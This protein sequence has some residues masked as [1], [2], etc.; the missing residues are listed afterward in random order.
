MYHIKTSPEVGRGLYASRTILKGETV[1]ICEILTLSPEDTIKIN[2]TDLKYYTFKLDDSRD[3][4]VLGDGE[5]FNHDDNANVS[6]RF[7]NALDR[8]RMVFKA[9][10]TIFKGEQLFIDYNADIKVDTQDYK[11]QK[12]LID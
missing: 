5:I 4:L 11:Q 1:S 6:Y 3:C 12:S 9:I 7:V 8:Q 2:E 10:K